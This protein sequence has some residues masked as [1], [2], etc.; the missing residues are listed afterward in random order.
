MGLYL[1]VLAALTAAIMSVPA[2]AV[3]Q[4]PN[5]VDNVSGAGFWQSTGGDDPGPGSIGVWVAAPG[6]A[7][8]EFDY[9]RQSDGRGFHGLEVCLSVEGNQAWMLLTV[10]RSNLP[11]FPVGSLVPAYTEDN[12]NG[13]ADLFDLDPP[14][15]GDVGTCGRL[16]AFEPDPV[17][18]NLDIHDGGLPGLF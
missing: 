14:F 16:V 17:R 5:L 12:G 18:G 9:R 2:A 7:S 3:A 6:G 10:E 11:T 15:V 8:D 1:T 13:S 4:S